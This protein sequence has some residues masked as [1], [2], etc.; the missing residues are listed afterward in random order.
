MSLANGLNFPFL[1]HHFFTVVFV[2]PVMVPFTLF[3][4]IHLAKSLQ[5]G[6]PA[7]LQTTQ[8]VTDAR[9]V[10]WHFMDK[11]HALCQVVLPG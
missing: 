4:Q 9:N 3:R 1:C 10:H 6:W 8:P 11:L 7:D 2:P 5:L